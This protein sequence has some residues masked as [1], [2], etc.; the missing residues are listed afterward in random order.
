MIPVLAPIL[1]FFASVFMFKV[2]LKKSLSADEALVLTVLGG[3]GNT[4]F[5]GFPLLKFF[6]GDGH[7]SFAVIFDQLTFFLLATM[8]QWYIVKSTGGYNWKNS[9]KKI[10]LFPPFI[11][12]FIGLLIPK[13][14]EYPSFFAQILVGLKS[15]VTP[16]AMLIVGYQLAKYV[17]F[18]FSKAVWFGL[19]YSLMISPLLIWGISY[20]L[21]D[22]QQIV[23]TSVIEAG[24]APMISAGLLLMDNGK[25]PQLTAQVLCW[26]IIFSFFT[27]YLWV[28]ILEWV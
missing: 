17:T 10:L 28:K 6:Y 11:A 9:A 4:S 13:S 8:A 7:L 25:L 3:L 2:I 1:L 27:S 14:Y 20:F 12:L 24:M 26:G 23:E 19:A 16:V 15:T 21:T 22:N 5:L 18:K